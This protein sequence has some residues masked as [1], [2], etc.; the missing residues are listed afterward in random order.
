MHAASIS[1]LAGKSIFLASRRVLSRAFL[2]L[3]AILVTCAT[4][5][6]AGDSE[7][8]AKSLEG[9]WRL[10]FNGKEIEVGRWPQAVKDGTQVGGREVRGPY[11]IAQNIGKSAAA[12]SLMHG[13]GVWLVLIPKAEHYLCYRTAEGYDLGPDLT[14][15]NP[16]GNPAGEIHVRTGGN[17]LELWKN[18][19]AQ[20]LKCEFSGYTLVRSSFKLSPGAPDDVDI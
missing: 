3:V 15:A 8:K 5:L 17:E 7:E 6:Q 11:R 1:R 16:G 10:L 13:T 14:A 18:T 9:E 4:S 12:L 2:C 20:A 19:S